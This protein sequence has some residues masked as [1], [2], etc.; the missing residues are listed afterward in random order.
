MYGWGAREDKH[1]A[2]TGLALINEFKRNQ[3]NM[4]AMMKTQGKFMKYHFESSGVGTMLQATGLPKPT[5]RALPKTAVMPVAA[6]YDATWFGGK[7]G[8][9]TIVKAF[10]AGSV[11]EGQRV[12]RNSPMFMKGKAVGTPAYKRNEFF[13]NAI[14]YYHEQYKPTI[15]K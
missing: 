4:P 14:K 13:L 8:G 2:G 9:Q 11:V 10:Q 12:F 7:G 3:G 5:E 1:R 15:R 6:I